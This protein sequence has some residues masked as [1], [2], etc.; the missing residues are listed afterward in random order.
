M[1]SINPSSILRDHLYSIDDRLKRGRPPPLLKS[2]DEDIIID[3]EPA[4]ETTPVV[5]PASISRCCIERGLFPTVP[6]FF[7]YPYGTSKGW[8]EWVDRELRNPSTCDILS[9]AGVLD[10]IFISKACDIRIEAKMLQHVVRR[11]STETHTFVCSWGEFAPT[12]EDVANIFHLP[13]CGSQYPFHIA[14]TPK[15]KLKLEILRKGAPTSPSTSLR[16][17]NWIQFFENVNRNEPCGLAAFISLWLGRFI[18]CDF[19]QDCLH[20]RVFPLALAIAHSS[21]LPLAPINQIPNTRL[22]EPD[23]S[24]MPLEFV[25]DHE[26]HVDIEPIS[27]NLL[28][29]FTWTGCSQ[30]VV[31]GLPA[32]IT[33]TVQTV[34][35][36]P[37][38]PSPRTSNMAADTSSQLPAVLPHTPPCLSTSDTAAGT[39][40]QLPTVLPPTPPSLGTSGKVAG[41]SP[42]LPAVLPCGEMV[43]DNHKDGDAPIIGAFVYP[44]TIAILRKSMDR[45]GS[46][47]EASD[48]TS[49]F[50]RCAALR[51]LGL[52]DNGFVVPA[53]QECMPHIILMAPNPIQMTLLHMSYC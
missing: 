19:S 25:S 4:S 20:E 52:G 16:F 10:A 47:M 6:L 30:E 43:D 18:F 35:K 37:A 24:G 32:T 8:S 22:E 53:T 21:T 15:D 17:S 46:F 23:T 41:T 5:D 28:A 51:V 50:S 33:D 34:G 9:R 38:P 40:P 7:Q 26:H 3:E 45:Y 39:S 13:L 48:I 27:N 29:C 11:W 1:T 12:L 2:A 31:L 36:P 44:E 49:S 42:Q 14:L